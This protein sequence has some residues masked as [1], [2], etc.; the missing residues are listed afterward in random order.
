[1][2]EKGNGILK[3]KIAA[4]LADYQSSSWVQALPECI[5]AMN[6]QRSVTTKACPYEIV[7]GQPPFASLYGRSA[8][9]SPRLLTDN[10]DECDNQVT[11]QDTGRLGQYLIGIGVQETTDSD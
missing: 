5:L 6:R 3:G 7:F 10:D 11:S 4:W 2:V 1:M 8:T 9:R